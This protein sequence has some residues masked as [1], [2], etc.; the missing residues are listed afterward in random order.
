MDM[1][2]VGSVAEV[3][4]GEIR[5]FELASGRIAVAQ[6]GGEFFAFG[7]ECTHAGCA[8]SEGELAEDER[9]VVCPCHGSAFDARTGEP[10]E[11]PAVDPIP[12]HPVRTTDGWIEVGAQAEEET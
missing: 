1:V 6:T 4:E 8:L 5:A 9:L 2:R 12:V 7:D 10:I 3:P 11:G